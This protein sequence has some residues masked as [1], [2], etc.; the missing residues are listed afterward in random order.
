MIIKLLFAMGLEWVSVAHVRR[1][2]T[3]EQARDWLGLFGVIRRAG[4][5]SLAA[6]LIPGIY[7]AVTVWGGV[8]WIV[9][10]FA[11]LLLLPPLGMINGLR[12][13]AMARDMAGESGPLPPA[14]RQRLDDPLFLASIQIRTAIAVGIVFL[15]TVKPDLL[16]SAIAIVVAIAVG[17]GFSLPALSRAR[18]RGR[19]REQAA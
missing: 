13:P 6:I 18:E 1:A 16:G 10:G 17:L 4:P 7:M 14:R 5:A 19:V 2:E 8:G 3:V 11:A 15:M 9:V 12:L